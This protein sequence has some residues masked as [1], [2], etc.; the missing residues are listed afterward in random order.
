V[1]TTKTT[2]QRLVATTATVALT[3]LATSCT[4][5]P[6]PTPAPSPT[7]AS[8]STEPTPEPEPSETVNEEQ[9]AREANIDAAEARYMDYQAAATAALTGGGGFDAFT[10]VRPFLGSDERI[11]WWRSITEQYEENEYKQVGEREVIAMEAVDYSGDPLND[12]GTQEIT[13]EVCLDSSAVDVLAS[14]GSSVIWGEEPERLVDDVVMRRQT[15]GRWTV[16]VDETRDPW[17]EC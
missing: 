1:T 5:T 14:D 9:A 15:D 2:R 6:E 8:P 13:F 11:T 7:E 3:L 12:E 17:E 16:M 10:D 4:G